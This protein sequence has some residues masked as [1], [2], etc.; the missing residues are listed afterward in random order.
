ML[1]VQTA[2]ERVLSCILESNVSSSLVTNAALRTP[3]GVIDLIALFRSRELRLVRTTA[4]V[5]DDSYV[6]ADDASSAS[7][8][9]GK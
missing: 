3:P 9:G 4:A 7:S 8:A 2:H 6:P 1:P 5:N